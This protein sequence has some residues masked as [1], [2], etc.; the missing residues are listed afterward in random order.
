[1]QVVKRLGRVISIADPGLHFRLPFGIDT[2]SSSPP[3]AC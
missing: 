1:V 3:S 2:C